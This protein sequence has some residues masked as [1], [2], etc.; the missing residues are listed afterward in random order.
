MEHPVRHEYVFQ[1]T[2]I[3]KWRALRR[4][5]MTTTVDT[6]S[7]GDIDEENILGTFMFGTRW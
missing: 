1:L 6:G 5:F 2:P 4:T 3:L 7:F